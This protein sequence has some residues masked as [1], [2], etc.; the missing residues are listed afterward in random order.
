MIDE[1]TTLEGLPAEALAYKLGN[2]SAVEWV[3]DQY[4]PYKSADKTIQ[5]RFNNYDF[6][7]YK[8][9]VIDLVQNVVYVSVETMKIVKEL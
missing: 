5:E 1:L 4:K 8:E 2:R 6:A 3:L 7:Q 9:Q